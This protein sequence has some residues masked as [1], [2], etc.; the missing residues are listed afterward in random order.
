MDDGMS[1][2]P[3]QAETRDRLR[4]ICTDKTSHG[5]RD[6]GMIH[7][8]PS[9]TGAGGSALWDVDADKSDLQPEAMQQ[10][11]RQTANGAWKTTDRTPLKTIVRSGGGVT[12]EFP[13]CPVCGVGR[14]PRR[15]RDDRLVEILKVTG[16]LDVSLIP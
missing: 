8:V 6:L 3:E 16:V 9:L 13:P 1:N 12:F 11:G 7:W 2:K 15:L 4:I 14:S 10:T 5:P